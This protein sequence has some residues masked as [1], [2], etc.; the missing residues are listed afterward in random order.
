[1]ASV[2]LEDLVPDLVVEISTPGATVYDTVSTDE[3]VT[4]LRNAFWEAHLFGFMNGWTESDGFILKLNDVSADPMP[5]D[6]Q[7]LIVIHAA[8]NVVRNELRSLNS[9]ASYKAGPVSYETQKSAQV[10]KGLLQ[11]MTERME[12]LLNRLADS[13]NATFVDYI[14]SYGARQTALNQ[15]LVDWVGSL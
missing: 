14:D 10:L 15:G 5:R 1:M 7:Q 4:R 12:Y 2:D 9:A 13:G 11:N 3:W 6:T 8:M